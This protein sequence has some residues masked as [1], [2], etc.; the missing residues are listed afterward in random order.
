MSFASP[1]P[2][3]AESAWAI[4]MRPPA[5]VTA[6]S[7]PL[8]GFGG[9]VGPSAQPRVTFAASEAGFG[10]RLLP[11]AGFAW[12]GSRDL[13]RTRS[14]HALLWL[15]SGSAALR[16]PRV[17]R[18]A[19]PV[20]FLP[21]G[22][23][24]ALKVAEA[25]EGVVLLLSREVAERATRPF[26]SAV[27]EAA[28]DAAEA[29]ALQADIDTIAAETLRDAPDGRPE[30]EER[31][32]HLALRLS[33]MAAAVRST[34][35]R[36]DPLVDRFLTLALRG[37]SGGPGLHD[38]AATL[39][40]TTEALDRACIAQCGKPAPDLVAAARIGR[41]V[42]LLAATDRPLADIARETGFDGPERL[43]QAVLAAAG[44][45]P[46]ALRRAAGAA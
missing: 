35:G 20:L 27:I 43:R 34:A 28:P 37:L 24:F 14:D 23:A 7:G 32:G 21:A 11:A 38:I 4:P 17:E 2:I 31:L 5:G 45:P 44:C 16:L 42:D 8:R 10:L 13:P 22:T 39:G 19:P 25:A 46:E 6:R 29:S 33:R 3:L 9:S 41:A 30:L 26:P 18:P 1:R 15:T 36:G 40:C 12:S